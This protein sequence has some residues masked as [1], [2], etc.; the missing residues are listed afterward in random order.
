M[1]VLCIVF[2]D[3]VRRLFYHVLMGLAA[4]LFFMK[5]YGCHILQDPVY[6]QTCQ[7]NSGGGLLGKPLH[8]MSKAVTYRI[9][10]GNGGS[11]PVG[12]DH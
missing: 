10:Y 12:V 5:R 2:P 9:R 3:I 6:I 1:K 8:E 7:Q 11:F 4:V